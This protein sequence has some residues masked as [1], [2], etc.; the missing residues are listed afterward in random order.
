MAG[1]HQGAEILPFILRMTKD[2]RSR[3][4]SRRRTKD[5]HLQASG[6]LAAGRKGRGASLR[7]RCEQTPFPRLL[8]DSG[9]D[10][11]TKPLPRTNQKFPITSARCCDKWK[12]CLDGC[13]ILN[14]L[15]LISV[16]LCQLRVNALRSLLTILGITIGV[17]SVLGVVS[18]GEGLRP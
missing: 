18:I 2:R 12:T 6:F 8:A 15:D 9:R 16:G 13:N 1:V 3:I 17:G 4:E 5:S 14:I 11:R 10:L 7:F